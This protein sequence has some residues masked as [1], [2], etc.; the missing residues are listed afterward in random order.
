M[1]PKYQIETNKGS[2]EV[3]FNDSMSGKEW[4]ELRSKMDRLLQMGNKNWEFDLWKLKSFTSS[5]LSMFLTLNITVKKHSGT[6]CLIVN[7]DSNLSAAL[8]VSK[9]DMVFPVITT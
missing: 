6:L 1:E 8:K 2:M 3:I 5:V 7:N 9:L 4:I